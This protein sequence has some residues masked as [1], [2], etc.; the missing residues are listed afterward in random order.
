MG[1]ALEVANEH[2]GA[3]KDK[4]VTG[5]EETAEGALGAAADTFGPDLGMGFGL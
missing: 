4:E 1:A 5:A 2:C 3:L